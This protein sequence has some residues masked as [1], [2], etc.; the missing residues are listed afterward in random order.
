[1]SRYNLNYNNTYIKVNPDI[2]SY[3]TV[4]K[5]KIILYKTNIYN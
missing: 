2:Y 5:L 4:S 1:M 3:T